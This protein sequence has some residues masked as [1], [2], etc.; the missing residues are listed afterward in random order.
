MKYNEI[1]KMKNNETEWNVQYTV[2]Q[3]LCIYY[4]CDIRKINVLV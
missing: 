4:F 1:T 3:P 2:K